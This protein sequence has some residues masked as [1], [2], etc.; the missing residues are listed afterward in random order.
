MNEGSRE[1]V[2]GSTTVLYDGKITSFDELQQKWMLELDSEPDAEYGMS[3]EAVY[4]YVDES[5]STYEDYH[6]PADP[7]MMDDNGDGIAAGDGGGGNQRRYEL[8]QP[9]DWSTVDVID[10]ANG[11]RGRTIDHIPW[12]GRAEEFTVNATEEDIAS[13]KRYQ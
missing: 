13:F 10:V 4:E 5:A 6:L 1:L 11:K 3:Y 7:N 12:T 9:E 2:S 8:T